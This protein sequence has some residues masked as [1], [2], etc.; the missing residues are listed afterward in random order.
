MT[1][2]TTRKGI[3][4]VARG[5][6]SWNIKVFE[7]QHFPEPNSIWSPPGPVN[8]SSSKILGATKLNFKIDQSDTFIPSASVHL[9]K[10]TFN[11]CA[12]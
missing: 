1:T 4:S 3:R 10:I 6:R 9:T 7:R 11:N 2:I 8:Q 12:V 5:W